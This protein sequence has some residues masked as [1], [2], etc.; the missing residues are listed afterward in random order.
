MN[1]EKSE[2]LKVAVITGGHGF[3]EKEFD[4][5]FENMDNVEFIRQDL[6][7]FVE[8]ADQ[9]RYEAVVFYNFHRQNPDPKTA[10]AILGLANRGQGIIVLHHAILAFPNWKEFSEISGIVESSFGYHGG[11]TIHV[12]VADKTHPITTSIDDWEMVDETYVMKDPTDGSYA[13]LTVDHPKSMK[14]IGWTRSYKN[15]RV[16]GFQSGHDNRTYA[17][18][19]FREVLTRAIRWVAKRL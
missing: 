4:A 18:P 17:N 14:V 9:S 13:L 2:K 7:K 1:S 11:Q 5:V 12:H 8:D 10:E 15:S 3:Q 19:Q 16:F 6:S